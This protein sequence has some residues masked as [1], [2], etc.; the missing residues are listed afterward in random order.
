MSKLLPL[1]TAALV[2]VPITM[3][4]SAQHLRVAGRVVTADPSLFNLAS[5]AE[6]T[7]VRLASPDHASDDNGKTW[8]ASS[9]KPDFA[10]GL[11]YGFRREPAGMVV[12]PKNGRLLSIYNALDTPGVDP[13]AVEPPIALNEYYLRYRVSEDGGRTWLFD[14]PIVHTGFTEKRPF[15]GI[16]R[17]A[18]GLFTG[19]LG[20]LPIITRTG[21]I[22]LPA[23]ATILGADGKL[24]NPAGTLTFTDVFTINGTWNDKG[25]LEWTASPRVSMAQE[26]S[27]RGMIEP[28]LAQ[29]GDGRILMVLRGS[30]SGKPALPSCRWFSI[31]KD[32]GDTWSAP[33]PWGYD[34][35]QPFF[36]PSSMS[37]LIRHSS[38]RIF[39]V[40]NI[41][42]ENCRGNDPRYPVV[43]G[44]VEPKSLR[45]QKSSVLEF[46]TKRPEDA[47]RGRELL[48]DFNGRV[49]LSHFWVIE[50]RVTHELVITYPRAFGG[51][52]KS[53]W[54]TV[55]VAVGS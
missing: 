27:T 36:S 30:N 52:K 5:Y 53:D 10:A 14:E 25:R 20:S 48:G 38:G 23:Q 31:S 3:P 35:G 39:W 43:I 17:G 28:T 13:N 29:F 44:E 32:D 51:Y 9:A 7:G 6:A 46:D 24:W 33:E 47:D 54:A 40:G 16:V 2:F 41:S 12:D 50:D 49:D 11:P 37:T 8:S 55:R 15:E 18:N 26:R 45:L 22:L 1:F 42:P 4:A 19:D 34:D 21:R